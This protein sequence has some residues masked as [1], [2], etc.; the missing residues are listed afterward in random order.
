MDESHLLAR[1]RK[2]C[3]AD[4]LSIL[5]CYQQPFVVCGLLEDRSWQES[6]CLTSLI[7][8]G[9]DLIKQPAVTARDNSD[10]NRSSTLSAVTLRHERSPTPS[11]SGLPVRRFGLSPTWVLL[12]THPWLLLTILG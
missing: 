9:D 10:L 8:K 12:G 2:V 6:Q 1:Q 4:H 11:G 7:S 5:K 3:I